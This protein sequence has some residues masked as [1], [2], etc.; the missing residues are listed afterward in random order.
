[1]LRRS[2]PLRRARRRPPR[3][4]AGRPRPATADRRPRPRWRGSPGSGRRRPAAS[5][6]S[7][8]PAAG[9]PASSRARRAVGVVGEVV[10]PVGAG[11]RGSGRRRRG[12][13]WR[14]RSRRCAGCRRG[15]ARSGASRSG[16]STRLRIAGAESWTPFEAKT[17]T[18]TR[19]V[20][21]GLSSEMRKGSCQS[22]VIVALAPSA[23]GVDRAPSPGRPGAGASGSRAAGR[24][25][26]GSPAAETVIV[27][28][29]ALRAPDAGDGAGGV[30]ELLGEAL[31]EEVD[32]LG[33]E[34]LLDARRCGPAGG[35]A[36]GSIDLARL[37]MRAG[38]IVSPS[39][40]AGWAA[41][42]R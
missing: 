9:A 6:A 37:T 12:R 33:A 8:W 4:R 21:T 14:G 24:S 3:P 42:L 36:S 2:K 29:A 34:V 41:P 13:G 35:M 16:G 10:A 30:E 38:L 39:K 25:G 18:S 11:E 17:P 28:V 15:R 31:A 19:E 22:R 26:R 27:R 23:E 40:A 7:G 1:M 20:T 5:K 32:A